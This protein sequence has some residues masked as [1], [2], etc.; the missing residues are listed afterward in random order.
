MPPPTT[1]I[2][3][4]AIH[5]FLDDFGL[6]PRV[7]WPAD[8]VETLPIGGG[9]L[10]GGGGREP[11]PDQLDGGVGAQPPVDGWLAGGVSGRH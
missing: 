9:P 4:S 3:A 7:T 11:C 5:I 10:G 2:A 1:A 8:T 6:A